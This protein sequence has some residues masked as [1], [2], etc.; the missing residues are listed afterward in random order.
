MS[1]AQNNT[2]TSNYEQD[3]LYH[4]NEAKYWLEQAEKALEEFHVAMNLYHGHQTSLG[5]L[6]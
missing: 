4:I 6:G 5:K 3:V 2:T 1:L